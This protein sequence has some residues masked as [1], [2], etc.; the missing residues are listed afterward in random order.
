MKHGSGELTV[1]PLRNSSIQPGGADCRDLAGPDCL[2][3]LHRVTAFIGIVGADRS[4]ACRRHS[5]G[6]I[7]P[8]TSL[9]PGL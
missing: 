3:Q 1:L 2:T 8:N 6:V 4:R 9:A 5:S 7:S